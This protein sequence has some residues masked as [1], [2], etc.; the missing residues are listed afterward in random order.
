[1]SG[2]CDPHVGCL[3]Y[4][5]LEQ[6]AGPQVL[7]SSKKSLRKMALFKISLHDAGAEHGFHAASI[8]EEIS[9]GFNHQRAV[10]RSVG[11]DTQTVAGAI[12]RYYPGIR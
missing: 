9:A 5:P 8:Q 6:S 11:E 1:M 3:A 10:K 12:L 4:H 7:T 2:Q